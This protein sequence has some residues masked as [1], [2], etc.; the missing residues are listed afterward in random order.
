MS[1]AALWHSE[2]EL[3]AIK[4]LLILQL[5]ISGVRVA[6]IAM[7]IKISQRAIRAMLPKGWEAR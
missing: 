6:D 1:L 7:T 2:K 5:V 3:T 4:R